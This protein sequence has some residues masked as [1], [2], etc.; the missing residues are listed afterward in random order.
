MMVQAEGEN[1]RVR[2]ARILPRLGPTDDMALVVRGPESAPFAGEVR[3]ALSRLDP[4][5]PLFDVQPRDTRL[6]ESL[7]S[8]RTPTVLL[9]GFAGIALL[10]ATVGTYGVLADTVAERRRETA[11]RTALGSRPADVVALGRR[12]GPGYRSDRG[13]GICSDGS[14]HDQKSSRTWA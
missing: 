11:T 12:R 7:G 6:N 14:E 10:L 2:A 5:V 1:H 4:S 8:R 9:L 3:A 13:R